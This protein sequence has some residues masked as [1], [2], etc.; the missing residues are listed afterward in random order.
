LARDAVRSLRD[1]W[2][3]PIDYHRVAVTRKQID[4]Q[5]LYEDYNPA[6]EDSQQLASLR[7]GD[8]LGIP[9]RTTTRSGR[10]QH[11]AV[12]GHAFRLLELNQEMVHQ[13]TANR[14]RSSRYSAT[15]RLS[16]FPD[17]ALQILYGIG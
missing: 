3:I 13:A 2:Y 10:S 15:L 17:L 5:E 11:E 4:E 14:N 7:R 9:E 16:F 6:K 12:I 8:Q 1:L